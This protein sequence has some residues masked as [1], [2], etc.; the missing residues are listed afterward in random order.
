MLKGLTKTD[1]DNARINAVLLVYRIAIAA[2]ML[3]HGWPKFMKV[4]SGD[5]RFGD[6]LGLGKE[7]SL[8][9]ATSAEFL[10]SLLIIVGLYTRTGAFLGACTMAT[11]AFIVHAEDPF[12][13]KEKALLFLSFYLFLMVVGP[14]KHSL[15]NRLKK[16]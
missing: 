11:A 5:F 9:L 8:V 15:D 10:G 16:S 4:V 12:S 13:G 2:M 3:T 6:P 1:I 7:V 14:G